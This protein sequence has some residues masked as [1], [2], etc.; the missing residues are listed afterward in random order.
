MA[1]QPVGCGYAPASAAKSAASNNPP[2]HKCPTHCSAIGMPFALLGPSSTN[3]DQGFVCICTR[4]KPQMVAAEQCNITCLMSQRALCGGVGP[5]FSV[6]GVVD[7]RVVK[8]IYP[9]QLQATTTAV[10]SRSGEILQDMSNST[11]TSAQDNNADMTTIPVFVIILIVLSAV[12]VVAVGCATLLTYGK[13]YFFQRLIPLSDRHDDEQQGGFI[14][15]ESE[16]LEEHH[17]MTRLH[18]ISASQLK[19]FTVSE[20]FTE[21]NS[22]LVRSGFS[23]HEEILL[24]ELQQEL[25]LFSLPRHHPPLASLASNN[26]PSQPIYIHSTALGA[27][28]P[29]LQQSLETGGMYGDLADSRGGGSVSPSAASSSSGSSSTTHSL[30]VFRGSSSSGKRSEHRDSSFLDG[31]IRVVKS[32]VEGYDE[33][34]GGSSS[35]YM[36]V[37]AGNI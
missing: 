22:T 16:Q 23:R 9:R 6:Y 8:P 12:A 25:K 20:A 2:P 28:S 36:D 33:S 10:K 4:H 27:M 21:S 18:L 11:A 14:V 32:V 31:R 34:V 26:N 13:R 1:W 19:S 37:L 17:T 24:A 3:P 7:P 15:E 30:G 29:Q 35:V 5:L